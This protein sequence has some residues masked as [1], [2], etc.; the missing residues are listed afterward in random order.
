MRSGT[1]GGWNSAAREPLGDAEVTQKV[2]HV[3]RDELTAAECT[4]KA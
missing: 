2:G 3:E 4:A 1:C